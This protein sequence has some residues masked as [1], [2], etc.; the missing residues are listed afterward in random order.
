MVA[1]LFFG[2]GDWLARINART[3]RAFAAWL[4]ILVVATIPLRYPYRSAVSLVWILSEV[5]LVIGLGAWT[6]GETPV[7]PE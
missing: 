1:A 4:L 2:P 3:R 6:S 5:A 7:E